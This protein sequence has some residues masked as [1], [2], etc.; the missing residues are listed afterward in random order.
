[1]ASAL[2]TDVV[3]A[4]LP[5]ARADRVPTVV[6]DDAASPSTLACLGLQASLRNALGGV[7]EGAAPTMPGSRVL[8]G[9][10]MRLCGCGS[11]RTTLQIVFEEEAASR[12]RHIETIRSRELDRCVME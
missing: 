12:R 1:M 10:A 2:I 8:V 9:E 4:T 7:V 6:A 11:L 3:F 5:I